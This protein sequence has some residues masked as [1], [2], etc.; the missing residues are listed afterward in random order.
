MTLVV[1]SI[2]FTRTN[3]F[4]CK[5]DGVVICTA[6]KSKAGKCNKGSLTVEEAKARKRR[7][8]AMWQSYKENLRKKSWEINDEERQEKS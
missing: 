5:S 7:S 4:A 1:A 6:T 2:I 8:D 3:C